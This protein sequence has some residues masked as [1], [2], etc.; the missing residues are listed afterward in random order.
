M[1]ALTSDRLVDLVGV[2]PQG[3]IAGNVAV[4]GASGTQFYQGQLI[5]MG[6]DGLVSPAATGGRATGSVCVGVCQQTSFLVTSTNPL[7]LGYLSIR[8]GTVDMSNDSGN[9]VTSSTLL[10]TLLFAVDDNTVSLSS[11]NGTRCVAGRLRG[12][13]SG[14]QFPVLV[15]V[16]LTP[17]GSTV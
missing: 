17:S 8:F 16:G 12:F 15:A 13:N 4:N 7:P 10:N 14:D 3:F 5:M 2:E 11:A 9:P 1:T 6:S